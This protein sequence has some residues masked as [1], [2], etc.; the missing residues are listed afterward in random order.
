MSDDQGKTLR[1]LSSGTVVPLRATRDRTIAVTGGKGGVGKSS[2]AASLAVHYALQGARV[3]IMDADL[4]MADL[5]QILGVAPERTLL[6][7]LNGQQASAVLADAHGVKLLPACNASTR[8]A[9]ITK[10]ER[11]RLRGLV[12]IVMTGEPPVDGRAAEKAAQVEQTLVALRAWYT[13]WSETA[14]AAID[15]R[16]WQVRLGL[17]R[18]KRTS[19]NGAADVVASS[20]PASPAPA[21]TPAV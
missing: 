12:D 4:G 16:D 13:D 21:P 7:V 1:E 5:N 2:I 20:S 10:A 17:A 8:L 6:D 3:L 19:K 9:N 14:R 15:R 18:R 11:Q